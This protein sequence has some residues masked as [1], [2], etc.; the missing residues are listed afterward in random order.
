MNLGFLM[1]NFDF[2]KELGDQA[3]H[4]LR[5]RKYWKALFYVLVWLMVSGGHFLF[6]QAASPAQLLQPFNDDGGSAR[7]MA[8]GSAFVGVADDA[9]ALL[10]NPAGLG[11][12]TQSEVGLHHDSWLVGTFQENLIAG[13]PLGSVGTL[14]LRAAFLDYGT[15]QGRDPAGNPTAPYSADELGFSFGWGKAV[16]PGFSL[17]AAVNGSVQEALGSYYNV[18]SGSLGLLYSPDP[19]WRFGASFVNFGASQAQALV[20]SALEAGL[21]YRTDLGKDHR[22]LVSLAGVVEPGGVD[23]A[24]VGAEYG[25]ESHYFLRAGYQYYAQDDGIMG[26]QGFTAGL[27]LRWRDLELDYAYVPYGDLGTSQRISL[28]YLFPAGGPPEDKPPPGPAAATFKPN[29]G[30]G[31]SQKVLT[32][33]FDVPP[34]DL[35]AQGKVLDA[36]GQTG[37]AMKLYEDELKQDSADMAAWYYL[38]GDYAKLGQKDYAVQCLE[39]VL[40]LDPGNKA[41]ADWLE[42]YKKAKP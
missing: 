8:M 40:S 36:Q 42:E 29:E 20:A 16:L 27:G 34:D 31:A 13:I 30:T 12:L 24:Q 32:L 6:G 25:F 14:G 37:Q 33:Q 10:I 1:G 39:K 26:L 41:L 3:R 17:G 22:L 9:T 15:F 21:S 11:T 19:H 5:K 18:V 35:V 23:R 2:R 4:L 38:G 28:S 7:S